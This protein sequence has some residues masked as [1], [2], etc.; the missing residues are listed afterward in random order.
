MNGQIDGDSDGSSSSPAH[1]SAANN[2]TSHHSTTSQ[3]FGST[4]DLTILLK[5]CPGWHDWH[6]IVY[7][8]KHR[9][10]EEG[11]SYNIK[12]HIFASELNVLS[13]FDHRVLEKLWG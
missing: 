9:F 12:N 11:W 13:V 1:S 4:N 6:A 5:I 8:D 10:T 2:L 7:S 3:F